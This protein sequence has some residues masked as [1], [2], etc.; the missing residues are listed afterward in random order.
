MTYKI[1]NTRQIEFI[2]CV[3]TRAAGHISFE[4]HVFGIFDGYWPAPHRRDISL[5]F[6]YPKS[7]SDS[8]GYMSYVQ[9][10]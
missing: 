9:S 8:L 5:N 6:L 1:I 4:A 3:Y 2:T 10:P 7:R